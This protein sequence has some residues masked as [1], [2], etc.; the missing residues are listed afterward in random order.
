MSLQEAES[1]LR[2]LGLEKDWP[3]THLPSN[4][5]ALLGLET[6]W[7]VG[8]EGI[9]FGTSGLDPSGVRAVYTTIG[10]RLS[11]CPAVHL[12]RLLFQNGRPLRDCSP[13]AR[14]IELTDVSVPSLPAESA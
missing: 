9:V 7:A 5:R 14:C 1:V 2:R 10:S 6:A 12:S 4:P 8:A 11:R 13:D 3:L